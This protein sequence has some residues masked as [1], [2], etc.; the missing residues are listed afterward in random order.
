GKYNNA[1]NLHF[2]QLRAALAIPPNS[3]N[4]PASLLS[5]SKDKGENRKPEGPLAIRA[6][7]V[8]DRQEMKG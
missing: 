2:L 8:S 5:L 7:C 3:A 4:G 6:G 1:F